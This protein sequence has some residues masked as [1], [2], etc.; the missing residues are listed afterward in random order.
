MNYT[1]I[2]NL[3]IQRAQDRVL[4]GYA[5]KHHIIPRC[6]GGDNSPENLVRLTAKEH[7]VAHRLL[8]RIYPENPKLVYA[9]WS[10]FMKGKKT[11]ERFTPSARIYEATKL[12]MSALFKQ[13][14]QERNVWTG[15]KHTKDSKK[16][17]SESAKSRRVNPKVEATRREKISKTSRKKKT[18]EH[19]ANISK[20]KMGSNNPM[21]GKKW[22]LENGKRVYYTL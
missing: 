21:F 3:I 15:R 1:R 2:Y 18:K 16:K 8:V 9:L 19:S 10:M 7:F 20:S 4:S 6:M 12:A 13:R 17:Q 5:E 11:Q 22:R 14:L